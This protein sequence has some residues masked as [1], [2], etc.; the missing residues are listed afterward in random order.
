MWRPVRQPTLKQQVG[1]GAVAGS[2]A[3]HVKGWRKQMKTWRSFGRNGWSS[4]L[5]SAGSGRALH[6]ELPSCAVSL[7]PLMQKMCLM[8]R[9]KII[10]FRCVLQYQAQNTSL[11]VFHQKAPLSRSHYNDSDQRG[12]EYEKSRL[13][14][15]VQVSMGDWTKAERLL[16][17]MG[18]AIFSSLCLA[19]AACTA[20]VWMSTWT[21]RAKRDRETERQILT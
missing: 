1:A 13:P 20:S 5:G 2:W 9:K 4:N 6:W 18:N 21:A 8:E 10:I 11:I 7:H 12:T 19:S 17:G 14:G 3:L 15:G 16:V